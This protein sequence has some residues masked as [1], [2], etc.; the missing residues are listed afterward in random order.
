MAPKTDRAT[1]TI[2]LPPAIVALLRAHRKEQN[3]R[4]LLPG[5]AWVGNGL[6]LEQDD[7]SPLSPDA[8][9]RAFYRLAGKIGK[10]PTTP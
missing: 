10:R 8:V 2:A 6:I 9:S 5:E 4:Q 7:G 1:R 3:E